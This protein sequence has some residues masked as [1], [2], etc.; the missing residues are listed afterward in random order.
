M[1]PERDYRD[2]IRDIIDSS[3]K[4]MQF[5]EGMTFESFSI[6]AKSV[7]AV[8]RALEIIGEAAKHI[9]QTVR[10]RY[11]DAP[12]REMAGLRDKLIHRYFGVNLVVVW[13]T[14]VEDVPG[15]L[16]VIRRIS[17]E[18]NKRNNS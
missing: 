18:W 13:K 12:W 8:I 5:V 1:T 9:P 7:F 14:V 3:E 11:S 16:P 10:E 15:F 4:A 2:Y 6:D 17:D